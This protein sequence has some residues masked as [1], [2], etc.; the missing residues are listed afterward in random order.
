MG[1]HSSSEVDLVSGKHTFSFTHLSNLGYILGPSTPEP[2]VLDPVC[3]GWVFR[4]HRLLL[5]SLTQGTAC[6][7]CL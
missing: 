3:V 4:T 1:T 6:Y 5:L 2:F 7:R